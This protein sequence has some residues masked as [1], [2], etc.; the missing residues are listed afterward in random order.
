MLE[1]SQV[2]CIGDLRSKLGIPYCRTH[3][4][5][6]EDPEDPCYDPTF[7]KSFKLGKGPGARRVYWLHEMI[8]WLK[9]KAA[10]AKA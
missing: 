9:N 8:A 10:L 4:D 5:R 6:L 3:L 1:N 2:I 7:P